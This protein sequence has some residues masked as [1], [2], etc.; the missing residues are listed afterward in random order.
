MSILEVMV[1]EITFLGTGTSHGVPII[2]CK[3]KTCL[4]DDPKNKRYRSSIYIKTGEKN[5]LI[6]T[7]PDLRMQLLE[8]NITDIDLVLFTHAHAD[9]IMGFD[10]LRAINRLK[11]EEIP[12]YGDEKTLKALKKKFEYIFEDQR[13]CNFAVPSV[14]LIELK[15]PLK[16]ADLKI[17]PLPV[18]HNNET[19]LGYKINNIAYITDCSHIPKGSI[20]KIKDVDLVILNALRYKSHPK[21]FNLF[22][23]VEVIE[24]LNIKKAYLTHISHEIEHN[25]GNRRLPDNIELAYDGLKLKI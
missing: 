4:S 9:H 24:S 19:V 5:I 6:D 17:T 18:E 11:K 21:H 10:D 20:E 14:K 22:E 7:T 3:C 1:L 16:F 13:E 25:E 8:H 23:A 12:C 15:K 2:G